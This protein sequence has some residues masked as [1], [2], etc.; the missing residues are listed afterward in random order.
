VE[1]WGG[2]DED[3]NQSEIEAPEQPD[4]MSSNL[5]L[6]EEL[7]LHDQSVK[8]MDEGLAGMH[9]EGPN[10]YADIDNNTGSAVEV[11]DN[12]FGC[13][14]RSQ[15]EE[16]FLDQEVTAPMF[17]ELAV[18]TLC[19][20]VIIYGLTCIKR[21]KAYARGNIWH[22]QLMSLSDRQLELR[23]IIVLMLAAPFQMEFLPKEQKQYEQEITELQMEYEK[24]REVWQGK[25]EE[26][27]K[28][29]ELRTEKEQ[30]IAIVSSLK[31]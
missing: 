10:G 15:S 23:H 7:Q 14:S 26:L 28:W 8:Q 27:K 21:T 2:T 31:S 17:E 30:L 3:L 16:G 22:R 12:Q 19:E 4:Y 24:L 5:L 25:E 6:L 13:S 18:P 9:N 29:D 20:P 1:P 11:L